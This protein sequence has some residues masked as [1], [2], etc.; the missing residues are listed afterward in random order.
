MPYFDCVILTPSRNRIGLLTKKIE[1]LV[2]AAKLADITVCHLVFDDCSDEEYNYASGL[3]E[4]NEKYSP[5]YQIIH[6]RMT[7]RHGRNHFGQ[8]HTK[9]FQAARE[10][11]FKYLLL[12]VDDST[13]CKDFFN[14]VI[15]HF[16]YRRYEDIS[17]VGMNTGWNGV[18]TM[19]GFS[20]YMDCGML[21]IRKA[22][23]ALNWTCPVISKR[24]LRDSDRSSGV[25][26]I[27]SVI[28]NKHPK[29]NL[30]ENDGHS[31][32]SVLGSDEPS[33]MF[34]GDPVKGQSTTEREA[35]FVDSPGH[36]YD[37]V[38]GEGPIIRVKEPEP[39]APP[40][41]RLT[42]IMPLFRAKYIGWLPF[43]SLVLQKGIDFKWE[44]LIAEEVKDE[45]FGAEKI[46]K[47]KQR[48]ENVGCVNLR[49][50][51]IQEWIPLS[52]KWVMLV[53]MAAE[54]SEVLCAQP[55]DYYASPH[56]LAEH[57]KVFSDSA[58]VW[59][60]PI[61][62]IHYLIRT[63]DMV[64]QDTT[65]AKRKDNVVGTALR[66]QFLHNLPNDAMQRTGIDG[67]TL[68]RYIAGVKAAKVPFKSVFDSS[69]NYKGALST[70]GFNNISPKSRLPG[71]G[72]GLIFSK[73][74]EDLRQ[75]IPPFVMDKLEASRE[76]LPK[77]ARV[78]PQNRQGG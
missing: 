75:Y 10:F 35:M 55:A 62:A 17:V 47:Y 63:G 4:L 3:Q 57:M 74:E 12:A 69:D 32:M 65:N 58:V 54:T 39:S 42:V 5:L 64:L 51:G 43:E 22:L 7:E 21:C 72:N 40:P 29:Y 19:W 49:Y 6:H 18:G 44:L 14:R 26:Y 68:K 73:Y 70:V 41:I 50:V 76:F 34:D 20:R 52:K 45:P 78:L 27:I 38:I 33:Q 37:I 1:L 67:W 56:K 2:E 25:G 77:H 36:V 46:L 66:P 53:E 59:H 71:I 13:P 48:L 23:Q 61:R 11:Q 30:A 24:W 8:L 60:Q 28:L 15:T 31:F 9:M 16:K